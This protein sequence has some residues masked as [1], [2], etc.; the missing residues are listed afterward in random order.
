[1]KRI[2]CMLIIVSCCTALP[3]IAQPNTEV[4]LLDFEQ[5]N[6]KDEDL[7]LK[8]ISNNEGYDNQP[9]FG[10]NHTIFYAATRNKQTDVAKYNIKDGTTTWVTNSQIGSE[11]SPLKMPNKN[12]VSTIRLDTTGLQRLYCVDLRNGKAKEL[13]KDLVVGYHVWYTKDILLVTV[14]VENRMDL[15][16]C[17][18]KTNTNETVAKNVGRSLHKIPG[19]NLVGFISKEEKGWVVKSIA[20]TTK[21]IAEIIALPQKNRDICWLNDGTILLP[22]GKKIAKFN[23]ATDKRWRILHQFEE[24]SA[25]YDITRMAVSPDGKYLALVS[26]VSPEVIVE[27]QVRTFNKGNLAEFA[28]CFSENVLVQR[29]PNDTMYVGNANLKSSYEAFFEKNPDTNVEVINRMVIGNKVIDEEKVTMKGRTHRQVALY[30]IRNGK[31]VSMT[32]MQ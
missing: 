25:I 20:P 18:L 27:K 6:K 24:A 5:L 10:D 21:V 4:Y 31:I 8:N 28:A 3:L 12:A 16:I 15:V 22:R 26:E 13:V 7:N 30:E 2:I 14:L 32:F 1:M 23:S 19:A 11:Y 17:N 29:F 9:S